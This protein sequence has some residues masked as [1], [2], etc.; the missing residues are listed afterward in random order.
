MSVFANIRPALEGFIHFVT[1]MTDP[2]AFGWSDGRAGL[3]LTGKR[4][5]TTARTQLEHSIQ[6]MQVQIGGTI[7]TISYSGFGFRSAPLGDL[8]RCG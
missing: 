6:Q 1:F 3:A 7:P 2:V 5:L 8:E 4:R